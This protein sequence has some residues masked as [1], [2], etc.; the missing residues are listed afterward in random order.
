MFFLFVPSGPVDETASI[1]GGT[2]T[3]LSTDSSPNTSTLSQHSNPPTHPNLA[4]GPLTI[5]AGP[6]VNAKGDN[7]PRTTPGSTGVSGVTGVRRPKTAVGPATSI[8]VGTKP[9]DKGP[10]GRGPATSAAKSSLPTTR[11]TNLNQV[12]LI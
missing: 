6:A 8:R 7:R 3:N 1:N 10:T 5:P 12:S 9:G 4:N 2:P 11:R